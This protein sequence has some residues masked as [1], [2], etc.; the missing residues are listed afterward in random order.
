MTY[1]KQHEN[2]C[3]IV[4]VLYQ[5]L[6]TQGIQIAEET[7]KIWIDTVTKTLHFNRQLQW[8]NAISD[9]RLVSTIEELIAVFA[10]R[11]RIYKKMGYDLEF[12][13]PVFGLNYDDFD[14]RSAI[15][16]TTSNGSVS[17][18]CRVI[19]DTEAK[20]P[21]DKNYSLAY[22]RTNGNRL[23]ELS[24]LM[25][26]KETK[27][28][29]QEFRWLTKGVFHVMR[30]NHYDILVSVMVKEHFKMYERFGGFR[31]E[32]ELP[33]YGNLSTPFIITSWK[34]SEYSPFFKRIFLDH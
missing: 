1:R 22:L 30:Q 6:H 8:D 3:S 20:L 17:G 28:L 34:I 12:P 25:I 15:L 13:D 7:Q 33:M 4:N 27:G 14:T 26:E 10:L 9:V 29:G 21:I 2:D 31:M 23:A 19:F 24:R 32:E 16:Y 11:S 18:T 5:Y